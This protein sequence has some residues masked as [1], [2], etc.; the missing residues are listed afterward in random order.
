MTSSREK[1]CHMNQLR[2]RRNSL[3]S[4]HEDVEF[5]ITLNV[6]SFIIMDIPDL[7]VKRIQ[8]KRFTFVTSLEIDRT[9][10]ESKKRAFYH[11]L[12]REFMCPFFRLKVQK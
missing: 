6:K 1:L 7:T 3:R 4:G 12:P 11:M 10:T 8:V 5:I 9:E 2:K